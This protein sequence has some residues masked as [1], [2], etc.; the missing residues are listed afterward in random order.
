[1]QY[2]WVDLRFCIPVRLPTNSS[3]STDHI[4]VGKSLDQ[5][6]QGEAWSGSL[7]AG[8]HVVFNIRKA[9]FKGRVTRGMAHGQMFAVQV[10]RSEFKSPQ[11]LLKTKALAGMVSY[12]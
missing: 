5:C 7:I 10:R 4:I 3:A 8:T 1:M 12:L 9:I 6:C 11:T 2:V